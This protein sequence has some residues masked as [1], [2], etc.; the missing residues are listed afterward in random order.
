MSFE[1]DEKATSL[2]LRACNKYTLM[3]LSPLYCYLNSGKE[4]EV[5]LDFMFGLVMDC[6]G[7]ERRHTHIYRL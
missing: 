2:V 6:G 1:T 7:K 4:R 5:S 3:L